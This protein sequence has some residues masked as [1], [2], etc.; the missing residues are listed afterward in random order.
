MQVFSK[1]GYQGAVQSPTVQ[2]SVFSPALLWAGLRRRSEDNPD[3]RRRCRRQT[4]KSSRQGCFEGSKAEMERMFT[5][6]L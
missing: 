5:P 2:A 4:K 3:E 1:A 6:G